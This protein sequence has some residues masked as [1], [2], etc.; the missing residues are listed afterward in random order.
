MVSRPVM[1][2][3]LPVK[4]KLITSQILFRKILKQNCP[5][6]IL[7]KLGHLS[8]LVN[9]FILDILLLRCFDFMLMLF[10]L[11]IM[12]TGKNRLIVVRFK[13]DKHGTVME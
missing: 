11:Y 7:I 8:Y 3:N 4:I 2:N 1:C 9:C 10:S 13:C 6:G 12:L 5:D